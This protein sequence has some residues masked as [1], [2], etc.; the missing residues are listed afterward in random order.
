MLKAFRICAAALLLAVLAVIAPATAQFPPVPDDPPE[1]LAGTPKSKKGAAGAGP[2]V[3]GN[4]TGQLNQVG[5]QA[6]YNFDLSVTARSAESKYPDLECVGKLT[7]IGSSKSYVFFI[8][9]ITKGSADK[10]GRCP[11]GTLTVARQGEDLAVGWFGTIRG[12]TIVAYGT[13]KKK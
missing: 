1:P 11:D 7:R 3:I 10:G 12:D 8:E 6:P 5:S 9:V 4:W 13:L 2:N